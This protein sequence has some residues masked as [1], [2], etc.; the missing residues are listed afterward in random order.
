LLRFVANFSTFCATSFRPLAMID[1]FIMP[2]MYGVKVSMRIV[3][4]H[5][6]GSIGFAL[7][8]VS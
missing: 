4:H 2:L 8:I 7:G 6:F 3:L 1:A 5:V